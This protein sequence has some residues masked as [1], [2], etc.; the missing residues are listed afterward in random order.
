MLFWASWGW[1]GPRAKESRTW[2]ILRLRKKIPFSLSQMA[3]EVL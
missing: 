3:V 1:I 2:E